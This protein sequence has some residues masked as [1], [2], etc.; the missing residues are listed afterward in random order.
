MFLPG[1]E[2]VLVTESLGGWGG[3]GVEGGRGSGER[4]ILHTTTRPQ[5]EICLPP[6]LLGWECVSV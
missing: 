3:G 1:W 5:G 4:G 6:R 2:Y